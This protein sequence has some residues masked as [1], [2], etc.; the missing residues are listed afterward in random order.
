MAGRTPK[1][2]QAH[3][4]AGSYRR[5]RHGP[6]P[7]REPEG[8]PDKPPDLTPE[9]A[10]FWDS[11]CSELIDSGIAKR[12]DAPAMRVMADLW[13]QLQRASRLADANAGDVNARRAVT[14]LAAEFGRWAA[15]FGLS[16]SDRLRLQG[17]VPE[18]TRPGVS[19]RQRQTAEELER[20][21]FGNND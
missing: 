4:L 7:E 6:I 13:G 8:R 17:A 3:I 1:P 5:D 21:Y 16:P 20:V 19:H 18:A 15:R 12:I 9:A 2:L 10:A 11:V 14:T